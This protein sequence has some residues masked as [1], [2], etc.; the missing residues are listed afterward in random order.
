VGIWNETRCSYNWVKLLKK[1][2]LAHGL[3]T[4]IVAPDSVNDWKVVEVL[5]RDPALDE[6]VS[7]IGVHYPGYVDYLLSRFRKGTAHL[8][9]HT[10]RPNLRET[11]GGKRTSP[12]RGDWKGVEELAKIYNRNYI[13]GKMTKTEIWS[14]IS[15]YYNNLP[16]PDSSAMLANTPWSGYYECPASAENGEFS[17]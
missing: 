1:T 4:R 14:P 11:S 9:Q 6:A 12:W 2:L 3:T 10:I 17:R 16:L 15:S 13:E 7:A 5:H 8:F